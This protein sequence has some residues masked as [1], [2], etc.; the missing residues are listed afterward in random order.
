MYPTHNRHFGQEIV[1][2]EFGTPAFMAPEELQT[3]QIS[4]NPQLGESL[5]TTPISEKS[6]T[7]NLRQTIMFYLT[8]RAT[9]EKG[10][11]YRLF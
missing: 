10:R 9:T 5:G 11:C 4:R 3:L 7:Y 6:Q 2:G 8:G 1:K